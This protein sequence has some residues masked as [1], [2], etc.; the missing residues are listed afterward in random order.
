MSVP[1]TE[2]SAT[3]LA[4][5][6]RAGEISSREVVDAHI[7]LLEQVNPR[8]NAVVVPR[9]E[10]AREEASAADARI[11]RADPAEELPPLLGVPC[12]I[13]ES[14]AV[15][16]MPNCAGLVARRELRAESTAPAAQRL[17]DA[18]A[19]PIGLT[20]TSELTMWIESH[21]HVYGRTRNAYD[22][23]R[24]AGGSSGGE[25]AAV[26]AGLAP[27]G[28]GSDI[29][30]S[31]RL[32]AFFNGVFGHKATAG[33]VPNSGQFPVTHGEAGRMLAVGPLSRRGEDLMPALR[34]LAGADPG[35]PLSRDAPLGDPAEV[36]LAGMPVALIDGRLIP[37]VSKELREACE[38]AA[39]A[40]EDAG[41]TV[42]RVPLRRLRT[43][44][45][46][47]LATLADGAGTTTLQ[48]LSAE[49]VQIR[50]RD[51]L[52]RRVPHTIATRLLIA[53]E[54]T[55]GRLPQGRT[56]RAVKAGERLA[57]E[58]EELVGEGVLLHPPFG[59]P[60][61]R[62][63]MTVGR[64][65]KIL[66]AAVFNLAGLPATETPLGLGRRGLPLGVQVVAGRDR[67]HVSIAVALELERRLGGWVPP[68]RA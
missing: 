56:R 63:G 68:G 25:G 50:A 52:S 4:R 29:G 6:I 11:A 47:Y 12:T 46:P 41:A 36:S 14:I 18:G 22:P 35:D 30:G 21:N 5:S 10:A 65:W 28:L 48:I 39:G 3:S 38:N 15:A 64:P 20:N 26:G 62:H 57:R 23:K 45:E 17:I 1:V 61:P 51:L 44:L 16:G 66:H 13:K 24:I 32:P 40:L 53:A 2:R 9:L 8:I 27:I 34:V 58:V 59:R 54:S 31:I 19:I 43:A 67:D 42:R 55:F 7:A 33:L 37:P 60:A 49:G